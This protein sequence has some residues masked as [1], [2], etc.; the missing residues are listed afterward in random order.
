MTSK[1][2][3]LSKL[4]QMARQKKGRELLSEKKKRRFDMG[5]FEKLHISGQMNK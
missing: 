3:F 2:S 1:T 5:G 4:Q